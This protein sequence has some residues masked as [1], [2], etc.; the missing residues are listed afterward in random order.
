M[1]RVKNVAMF[2]LNTLIL[3]RDIGPRALNKSILLGEKRKKSEV[4][5]LQGIISVKGFD[6]TRELS[7]DRST[8]VDM[9]VRVA[10]Y[11]ILIR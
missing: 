4:F 5:I 10:S 8:F 1:Y 3:F 7:V 11:G 6:K 9:E 2:A